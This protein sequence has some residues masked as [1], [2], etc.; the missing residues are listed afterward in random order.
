MAPKTAAS[1]RTVEATTPRAEPAGKTGAETVVRALEARGT[2]FVFGIP[3]AKIDSVFNAL[4]DSRIQTVVCRHEQ[5]AAFI[6]GGIGRMTGKAGVAI[7]TSGPGVSN[8]VTGLATANSE[9]DPVVA[10]GGAVATAEALKQI[11]QTMDSVSILKPVTKFSAMVQSPHSIVEVVSNAFRAAESG[12]P[13]AAFV[14]LPK[15]IM[16]AEYQG[17]LLSPPAFTGFGPADSQA[18]A[19]AAR[20]IDAVEN[21]V[22]LLACWR[23]GPSTPPPCRTSSGGAISPWSERSRPRARLANAARGGLL[24]FGTELVAA[25]DRSLVALLGASPG[26]STAAFIAIGVLEKCFANQLRE[27]AWLSKLKAIIPSYGVSLIE[28]A[29]L[30]RR[31]RADTAAVLQLETVGPRKSLG[32]AAA[33]AAGS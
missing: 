29:E 3:G 7:A 31:I 25:A 10:L 5:N 23:A 18:L 22:I 12:R 24:E 14:S 4:V 9:G 2:E 27:G 13:G 6:A 15:D 28:D 1:I 30:T 26:A 11:H 32:Q 8:L 20:L 17:A 21:P 19:E 16:A 33:F